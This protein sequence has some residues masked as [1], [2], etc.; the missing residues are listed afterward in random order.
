MTLPGINNCP[1]C[2]S[3]RVFRDKYEYKTGHAY[4]IYCADCKMKGP[5]KLEKLNA[6]RA[7]NLFPRVK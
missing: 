3:D 6:I 4:Q 7:W 2:D 1:Y 5:A